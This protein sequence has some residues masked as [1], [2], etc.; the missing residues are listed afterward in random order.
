MRIM[1]WPYS[2]QHRDSNSQPSEHESPPITTSPGLPPEI[3]ILPM[4]FPTLNQFLPTYNLPDSY[5]QIVEYSV[6]SS[7]K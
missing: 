6:N 7:V 1:F 2:I 3:I 4:T 5:I